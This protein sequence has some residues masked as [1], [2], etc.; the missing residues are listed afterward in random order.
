MFTGLRLA[1]GPVYP[2]FTSHSRPVPFITACDVTRY[3]LKGN[4]RVL[5]VL[6]MEPPTHRRRTMSPAEVM[7]AHPHHWPPC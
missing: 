2:S 4:R 5:T 6:V 3:S 1:I 7:H